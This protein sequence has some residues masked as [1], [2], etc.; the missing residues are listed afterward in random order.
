MT[1]ATRP[2]PTQ[3]VFVIGISQRSGTNFLWR[4]LLCHPECVAPRPLL[5]DHFL[6]H[7]DVLERYVRAT[8]DHWDP[9]WGEFDRLTDVLLA[10]LGGG[11]VDLLRSLAGPGQVVSKTPTPANL[12]L[13]RRVFPRCRLVVLVRDGRSVA[14]S[15][16]HGFGLDYEEAFRRWRAGAREIIDA[17]DAG[18][19][20]DAL[21]RYED[22]VN[23]PEP[24]L[25][26]MLDA[27]ALDPDRF[28][29]DRARSLPVYG[30]SFH[31]GGADAVHWEPVG[32]TAGFDPTTR[33]S[34]WPTRRHARFNW[35]AGEEMSML[36]YPLRGPQPGG[37]SPRHHLAD[38]VWSLR[39]R[40]SRHR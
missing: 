23:E 34:S 14:E 30:S 1:G 40:I 12:R 16:V 5:E 33:D 8:R 35:V 29:W 19:E 24:Q 13:F 31:R 28:D 2:D 21:V 10:R 9:E 20:P 22:L 37:R 11:I 32:E 6:T 36:G 3:P 4:L 15:Y 17:L 27:L 39:R 25:H 26:R 18:V 38:A 7:V